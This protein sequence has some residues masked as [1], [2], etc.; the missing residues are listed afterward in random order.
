MTVYHVLPRMSRKGVV[1]IENSGKKKMGR[2]TDSPK[3]YML[4]VRMDKETVEKLDA[5]CSENGLNRSEVV[6]NG[7][8]QQYEQLETPSKT[9]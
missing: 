3:D 1:K 5:V 2:P 9:E 7:I 4:R 8:L 6:R